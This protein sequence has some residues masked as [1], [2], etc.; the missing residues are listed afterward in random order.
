MDSLHPLQRV[1]DKYQQ[2]LYSIQK[3]KYGDKETNL[4]DKKE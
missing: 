4:S 1:N 2:P 3:A